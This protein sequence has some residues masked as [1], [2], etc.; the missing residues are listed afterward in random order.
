MTW[1][2]YKLRAYSDEHL[3][4]LIA[5]LEKAADETGDPLLVEACAVV[6]DVLYD[7][8]L[9]RRRIETAAPEAVQ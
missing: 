7:R 8:L 2:P 4:R 5:R 3:D 1:S 9:G 6:R